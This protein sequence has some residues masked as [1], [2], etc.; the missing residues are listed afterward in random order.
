[1]QLKLAR[2]ERGM[3]QFALAAILGSSQTAASK[4]E[5]GKQRPSLEQVF[6][7]EREFGIPAES[8]ADKVAA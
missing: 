2:I 6:I 1:M 3:N 7:I 8:W 5:T 4:I